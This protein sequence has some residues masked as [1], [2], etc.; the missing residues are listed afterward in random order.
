VQ[1][2]ILVLLEHSLRKI[3]LA[4]DLAQTQSSSTQQLLLTQV[5][6]CPAG[7]GHGS[8]KR[9]VSEKLVVS[10]RNCRTAETSAVE[11]NV[12]IRQPDST[13]SGHARTIACDRTQIQMDDGASIGLNARRRI[14]GEHRALDSREV[15][16]CGVETIL[17]AYR[18]QTFDLNA[19]GIAG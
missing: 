6:R 19:V 9:P 15:A 11:G 1:A 12:G 4:A 16:G 8:S 17:I 2:G 10:E 18:A 14:T 13:I 7:R 3:S 5:R